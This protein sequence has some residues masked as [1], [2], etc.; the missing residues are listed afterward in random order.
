MDTQY[1]DAALEAYRARTG[2]GRPKEE[3]LSDT[4]IFRALLEEAQ[5]RKKLAGTERRVR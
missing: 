2:D 3:L 5:R 1:F 4:A